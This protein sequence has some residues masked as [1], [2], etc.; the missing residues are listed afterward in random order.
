M[1][2]EKKK[3]VAAK[4]EIDTRSIVSETLVEANKAHWKRIHKEAR[5]WL[6]GFWISMVIIGYFIRGNQ[7]GRGELGIVFACC[8]LAYWFLH[9]AFKKVYGNTYRLDASLSGI[10]VAGFI[11]YKNFKILFRTKIKKMVKKLKYIEEELKYIKDECL[12]PRIPFFNVPIFLIPFVIEVIKLLLYKI[13]LPE[14]L[15]YEI[16]IPKSK[17]LL[18]LLILVLLLVAAV[19]LSIKGLFG[20]GVKRKEIGKIIQL[21]LKYDLKNDP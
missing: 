13:K 21:F 10:S 16:E 15:P 4:K 19:I 1:V 5:N 9:K 8:C 11:V 7:L 3:K 14:L 12:K 18:F 17:L 2:K 6:V 20:P